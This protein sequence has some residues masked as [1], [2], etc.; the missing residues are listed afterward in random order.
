MIFIYQLLNLRECIKEII[1]MK[2][3][4]IIVCNIVLNYLIMI[5]SH[6]GWIIKTSFFLFIYN[7]FISKKLKRLKIVELTNL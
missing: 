3:Y 7:F 4:A 1:I 5:E 2:L 6:Y